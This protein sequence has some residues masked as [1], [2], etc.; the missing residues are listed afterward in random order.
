[1]DE[2]SHTSSGSSTTLPS[3]S[4][5]SRGPASLGNY[6]PQ[7]L[8]KLKKPSAQSVVTGLK[9]F[10]GQFPANLTRPQAARR[11]HNFLATTVPRLFETQAFADDISEEANELAM[12]GLEKFVMLKLY[13]LLF[14]H[15]P[16]DLREDENVENCIHRSS[17]SSFLPA[18]VQES[19]QDFETAALELQKVDQYRV[20]RD[21]A[22]C[23]L[24]AYRIVEGIVEEAYRRSENGAGTA[25]GRQHMLRDALAGLIVKAAPPN[26]YSNVEFTSAFRHPSHTTAEERRCFQDLGVA[27]AFVTDDKAQKRRRAETEAS[28][29]STEPAACSTHALKTRSLW[30]EDA[31]VTFHFEDHYVDD[32]LVGETDELL[33]EYHRMVRAL[34]E[35]GGIPEDH[36]GDQRHHG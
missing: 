11:I 34:R 30:L 7:L 25:E 26:M 14:R 33:D 17:P 4:A 16:A 13:K 21:K 22:V 5:H 12:E 35:L 15:D 1:M 18:A 23:L 9:D 28:E 8:E 20:P 29:T 32:L 2:T 19:N 3:T 10:V 36:R 6:Y 31:G 24:N 27:L